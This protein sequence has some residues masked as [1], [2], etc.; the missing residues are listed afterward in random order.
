LHGAC[1]FSVFD[2]PPASPSYSIFGSVAAC[3]VSYRHAWL[4]CLAKT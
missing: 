2:G 1:V 4:Q 3:G